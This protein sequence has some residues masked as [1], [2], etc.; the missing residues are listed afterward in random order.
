LG[1]SL[2]LDGISAVA[3]EQAIAAP[4]A[5]R[6]LADLRARVIKVERPGSGGGIRVI[7]TAPTAAA[8]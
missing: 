8:V 6:H 2:P 3:C 4:L 7:A 1:R 5:T